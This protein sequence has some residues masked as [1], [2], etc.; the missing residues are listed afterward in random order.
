MYVVKC[1]AYARENT[2]KYKTPNLLEDNTY[3][4]MHCDLVPMISNI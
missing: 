2:K 4:R 1:V 3:H